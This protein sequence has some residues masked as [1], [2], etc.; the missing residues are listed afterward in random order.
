MSSAA[1][2]TPPQRSQSMLLFDTDSDAHIAAG[3]LRAQVGEPWTTRR[4]VTVLLGT[5][6]IVAIVRC[7]RS[8]VM[9]SLEAG[10]VP[11]VSESSPVHELHE[12]HESRVAAV[13]VGC[14][15]GQ[16]LAC[17]QLQ[18]GSPRPSRHYQV[19]HRC[20]GA[21]LPCIRLH[22]EPAVLWV[23]R[24]QLLCLQS[25]IQH[26]LMDCPHGFLRAVLP[27]PVLQSWHGVCR[28]LRLQCLRVQLYYWSQAVDGEDQRQRRVVASAQRN[29][30]RA[31]RGLERQQGTGC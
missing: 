19:C 28:Q 5:G 20:R 23:R 4:V 29:W 18:F 2:R 31:V 30:G 17:E 3:C 27:R 6:F 1:P 11:M 25:G 10:G 21:I 24:R 15:L 13:C 7:A 14:R 12:V 16:G 22:Q 26:R 8:C 9:P